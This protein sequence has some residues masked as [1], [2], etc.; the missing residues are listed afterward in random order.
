MPKPNYAFAK[1]QREIAKKQKA[2]EKRARKAAGLSGAADTESAVD[3]DAADQS[4]E[5]AGDDSAP[6]AGPADSREP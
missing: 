5:P 1:R 3:A 4:G 6:A 2:D